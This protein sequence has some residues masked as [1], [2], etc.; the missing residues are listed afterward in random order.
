LDLIYDQFND[1]IFSIPFTTVATVGVFHQ[2]RH[3]HQLLVE[4]TNNGINVLNQIEQVIEKVS[5]FVGLDLNVSEMMTC[6]NK[7]LYRNKV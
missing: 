4:N 5:S 3:N 7:T 6:V 1:F 2:Q